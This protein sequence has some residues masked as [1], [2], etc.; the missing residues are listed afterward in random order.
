MLRLE[1]GFQRLLTGLKR[2]VVA[3]AV[4]DPLGEVVLESLL[5]LEALVEQD[6]GAIVVDVSDA[7]PDGLVHLTA[8][9]TTPTTL[10]PILGIYPAERADV[11]CKVLSRLATRVQT[12]VARCVQTCVANTHTH[13]GQVRL[14]Q[15]ST[16]IPHRMQRRGIT[17][18]NA[19]SVY[20][21]SPP[22]SPRDTERS[23]L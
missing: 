10:A 3:K 19:C 17:A 16:S 5:L 13:T 9:C 11:C 21:S 4:A 7:S 1:E 14:S 6:D 22:R 15:Y 2:G 18:R 12:C 23:L 20:H 8:V